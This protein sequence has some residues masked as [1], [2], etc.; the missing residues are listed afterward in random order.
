MNIKPII[1]SLLLPMLS[2]ASCTHTEATGDKEDTAPVMIERESFAKGAD[3]SW[4]TQMVSEGHEFYNSSGKKTSC[5]AL[6]K[7]IGMNAVRLRVWVNPESGWNGKEDV[8]RKAREAK[9]NGMD[10]MIDFHFSDTWADPGHQ[11]P[12]AA[13]ASFNVQQ[14]SE[15]VHSHVSDILTTLKQNGIDVKWVQ[16]GNE[17]NSGMMWPLGKVE[18]QNAGNFIRLFNAGSKAAREIY[19]GTT[20]ILHLSNGHDTSMYRW[21]FDLMLAGNAEYDMIGMSLYPIWWENGGWNNWKSPIN[22][23]MANIRDVVQRYGKPVM[24]CETGGKVTEAE[25][26]RQM[27]EYLLGEARKIKE[28]HGVFYWEPQSPDGY[29]G[30]YDMGAFENGRPTVALD[31][32]K[33]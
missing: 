23:C 30:G 5:T 19:P 31:P 1:I 32:F 28:C 3:I 8:L 25:M 26:S 14:M 15:A 20:V 13:W 9:E 33:Q 18:G 27:L 29:N 6:M 4:W 2:F 16:P 24:I 21:F 7:E 10:I 12:P 17:L 11:T 22:T